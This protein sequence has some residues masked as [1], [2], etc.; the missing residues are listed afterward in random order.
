MSRGRVIPIMPHKNLCQHSLCDQDA[1][2]KI[3]GRLAYCRSC[4]EQHCGIAG[5]RAVAIYDIQ[6]SGEGF[7]PAVLKKLAE[8]GIMDPNALFLPAGKLSLAETMERERVAMEAVQ[9]TSDSYP[10]DT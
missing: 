6:Q 3:W 8:G 7:T 5:R 10:I 4:A 9:F 2:I 1:C